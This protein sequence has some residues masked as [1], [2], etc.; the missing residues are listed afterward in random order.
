MKFVA[1]CILCVNACIIN[2]QDTLPVQAKQVSRSGFIN[3]YPDRGH[4][5]AL[6]QDGSVYQVRLSDLTL[7]DTIKFAMKASAIGRDRNGMIWAADEYQSLF[8]LRDTGWKWEKRVTG[9]TYE[10]VFDSRNN[11]FL[12]TSL[13][14]Y[15][16][17]TEMFY[18]TNSIEAG[19]FRLSPYV[20][21]PSSFHID[22]SDNIWM[23]WISR[24]G[25]E[26]QVF[27]TKSNSYF[28]PDRKVISP[29]R[30]YTS[31]VG[32]GKTIFFTDADIYGMSDIFSY[33][34]DS[35]RRLLHKGYDTVTIGVSAGQEEYL[36][37]AFFNEA[38]QSIYYFSAKGLFRAKY[39][40]VRDKLDKPQRVMPSQHTWFNNSPDAEGFAMSVSKLLIHEGMVIYLAR[41]DGIFIFKDGKLYNLR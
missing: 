4:L 1:L 31:I 18:A 23:H 39:D 6:A 5:V 14:V 32:T 40:A 8:S 7:K 24:S 15:N 34:G 19:Y 26:L 25:G 16:G 33:R 30:R 22:D 13:G 17:K 12:L 38:D 2:A 41:N 3:I 37:A 35:M 21:K 9:R 20:L 36:G 10:F 11:L 27:S 29:F 28:K